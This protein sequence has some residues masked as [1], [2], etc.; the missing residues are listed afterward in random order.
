MQKNDNWRYQF[1]ALMIAS[2]IGVTKAEI[3]KI[4]VFVQVALMA[5]E[6]QH[7]KVRYA[8]MHMLGQLADD[9]GSEFG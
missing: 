4:G 5:G 7:P 8:T 6:H 1:A 3:S 9:F 2:Q